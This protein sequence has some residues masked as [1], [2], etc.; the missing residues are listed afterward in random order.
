VTGILW[1]SAG[2]GT[3]KPPRTYLAVFFL[4]SALP[5][6]TEDDEN[7]RRFTAAS[8]GKTPS[9]AAVRDTIQ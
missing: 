9:H 4:R 7:Y 3:K 8:Q 6:A 2:A 5:P 1:E